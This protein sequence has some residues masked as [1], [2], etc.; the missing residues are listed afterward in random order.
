MARVLGK[1]LFG[2][3]VGLL[4]SGITTAQNETFDEGVKAFRLGRY[5]EAKQ[6]F[7]E[8]LAEDPTNVQ[9]FEIWQKT[10]QAVWEA[11]ILDTGEVGKIAK[12]LLTLARRGRVERSRD[13]DSINELVE[14]ATTGDFAQ[15]RKAQLDLIAKHGEFAVPALVEK[16]GD[17]D[18]DKGQIYAILAL[19]ELSRDATLPLVEA[20]RSDNVLVRRNG[21]AALAQIKDER[22]AAALAV[23]A[24]RDPQEGVRE[25][26]LA[27]LRGLGVDPG[28]DPVRLYVNDSRRYLSGR[29]VH[30][31]DESAVVWSWQ[32]GALVAADVPSVIYDLELSKKSAHAAL[33]LDPTNANAEALVARAYL[34]QAATI[35]DSIAA[36]P[37]DAGLEAVAGQVPALRMLAS[38]TGVETVRRAVEDAM[39]AGSVPAAVAGIE[40]LGEIESRDNLASSPLVRAV[41]N[42]DSRI[43]YAA[44]LALTKA[45]G[46]GPVPA[47]Q[48]VVTRLAQAVNERTLLFVKVIDSNPATKVAVEEADV[49]QGTVMTV[50]ASATNAIGELYQFPNVDVVVINETL[51]DARPEAVIGLIRKDPRMSKTKIL[52]M[53]A[54]TDA[55]TEQFGDRVDGVIQGPVSADA[56]QAAV[57][58]A[59]ADVEP[60]ANR[61]RGD[62]VAVAASNALSSLAARRVNVTSALEN[63][64]GQLGRTDNVAIPAATALGEGGGAAEVA[65]LLAALQNDEASL[66]LKVASA[67][68][69]GQIL[70]RVGTI[71][72]G[73]FDQMLAIATSDADATL[74]AAVVRALGKAKLSPE[75]KLKL[76][77]ALQVQPM[78]GEGADG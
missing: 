50:E 46:D 48:M 62:R 8:V 40:M 54:N 49:K 11:L 16:L 59:L 21:A 31:G 2:L 47:E 65:P 9:A 58:E 36:N 60:D 68:A 25:T 28:S 15:R 45:A 76:I 77:E 13:Q 7:E 61:A 32:D 35:T 56:L 74:R 41:S 70:G 78:V 72:E 75:A 71:D 73:M 12:H 39:Q 67:N 52:V 53:A 30:A 27:A 20:L 55:A 44:A 51:A 18:N 5:E 42:P 4:T 43:G 3:V 63:L 10:D 34:A 17:A 19:Y 69:V 57:Q 22:A 1:T 33:R 26:A 37:D 29:G 38:A 66:D 14:L 6:K 23:L 64:A 24:S